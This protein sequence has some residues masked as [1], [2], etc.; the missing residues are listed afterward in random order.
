[1]DIWIF[2]PKNSDFVKRNLEI[3]LEAYRNR[4]SQ[5]ANNG[6][7]RRFHDASLGFLPSSVPPLFRRNSSC[8][9][10]Q[11]TISQTRSTIRSL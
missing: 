10:Q 1:M 3:T 11:L 2:L 7:C 4:C 5:G 8:S 6:G 9:S